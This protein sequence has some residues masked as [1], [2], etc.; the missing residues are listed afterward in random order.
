MCKLGEGSF[1]SVFLA[2]HKLSGV[3]VAIKVISKERI[4]KSFN[5]NN[6]VFQELEIM[7]EVSQGNCPNILKLVETFEDETYF[8]CV[9]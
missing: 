7:R 8:T 4:A 5:C 2:K 9:T 6:E 3:S 1:G